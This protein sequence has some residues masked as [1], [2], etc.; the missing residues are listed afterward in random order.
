MSYS[1]EFFD[2]DVDAGIMGLPDGLVAR[3]VHLA[4]RMEVFGANLGMPHT[5]AMGEGLFEMHPINA[6]QVQPIAR[7]VDFRI[8]ANAV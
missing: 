8:T 6:R 4:D 2:N 7:V 1:V 5:R 3:F